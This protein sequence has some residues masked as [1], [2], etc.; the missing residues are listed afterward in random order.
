MSLNNE[1]PNQT[2]K[3]IFST[4]RK[5]WSR[6]NK[7]SFLF[8]KEL[9]RV[10]ANV[11][12]HESLTGF[13]SELNLSTRHAQKLRKVGREFRHYKS[14]QVDA[15]SISHLV[16]MASIPE[17][18]RYIIDNKI[19]V[20]VCD[21][22]TITVCKD[23]FQPK[24]FSNARDFQVRLRAIKRAL[25]I[26]AKI[27]DDSVSDPTEQEANEEK[28]SLDNIDRSSDSLAVKCEKIRKSREDV[29]E[30]LAFIR[31]MFAKL[32]AESWKEQISLHSYLASYLNL[33]L[34]E[35]DLKTI[36]KVVTDLQAELLDKHDVDIE[37]VG[38]QSTRRM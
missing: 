14:A 37:E 31:T 2:K 12:S 13:Y 27:T 25:A 11:A 16:R 17:I 9:E 33:E 5:M 23:D 4:L 15:F 35:K 1:K 8:C 26:S 7:S 22:D 18:G 32:Y 36:K 28:E 34:F 6:G 20:T 29:E 30:K 21:L 3:D 24:L 10:A 38:L 19:T